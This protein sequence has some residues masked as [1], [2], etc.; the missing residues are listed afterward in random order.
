MI[1]QFHNLSLTNA[2]LAHASLSPSVKRSVFN[3]GKGVERP[4]RD[5]I[6]VEDAILVVEELDK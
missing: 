1:W 2:Q 4:G 6:D 3:D 5:V